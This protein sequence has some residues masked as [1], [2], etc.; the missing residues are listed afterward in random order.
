MGSRLFVLF[1]LITIYTVN[2]SA[3]KMSEK[4]LVDTAAFS[5]WEQVNTP[6]VSKNGEYA[7]FVVTNVK[8]KSSL[9]V[10][11]AID[12]DSEMEWSNSTGVSFTDDSRFALFIKNPDSLCVVELSTRIEKYIPNVTSFQIFGE[13]DAE[14]LLYR[15]KGSS[16]LHIL[17]NMKT[18][19]ECVFT[20]VREYQ[21]GPSGHCLLLISENNEGI[22][23]LNVMELPKGNIKLIWKGK[24]TSKPIFDNKGIQ[25]A[26]VAENKLVWTYKIGMDKALLLFD[27]QSNDLIPNLKFDGLSYFS[28]DGNQLFFRMKE[29]RALTLQPKLEGVNVDIWSYTD[30]KLQ[31]Q[32]LKELVQKKARAFMSVFDIKNHK[33]IRLEHE[34]EEMVPGQIIEDLVLVRNKGIGDNEYEWHWNNE[35]KETYF[36]ISIQSG[37]RNKISNNSIIKPSLSLSGK[38]VIYYDGDNR[39]YFSYETKTGLVRNLTHNI[40]TTWT[41]YKWSDAPVG[42]YR[43]LGIAGFSENDGVILIYDQYDIW[44]IDPSGSKAPYCLTNGYGRT[45]NIVF[46]LSPKYYIKPVQKNEELLLSA[47]DR[48]SKDNGFY[49]VKLGK[50]GDPH[51]LTMGPYMY[52][53]PPEE[54]I[55]GEFPQAFHTKKGAVWLLKR[56]SAEESPNWFYTTDFKSFKQLTFV[57]PEKAY[58]WLRTELVNFTTLDHK[59]SQGV[60]YKPENF[61]PNRKYPVIVHY[62][63]KKSDKLHIFQRPLP[64]YAEINIP[65]FVSNG[66]LVFTPDI[67]YEIGFPGES[68]L[69]SI[70]G[71]ANYLKQ[72]KWVDSTKMG[73]QGHSFGGYE[74]NYIISRT[75]FFAAAE[76]ASGWGNFISSYNSVR[77]LSDGTSRQSYYEMVRQRLGVTLWQ[78]ANYF[79]DNSPIF[80]ADKISTPLL[81]M[82]N[83]EDS[84]VFWEQGIEFFTA[85]RRLG[86]KVWMLQYDGEG[87]G[88]WWSQKNAID[89]TIRT[90]Q[91]F[92][93]YLKGEKSPKWMVGGIP[94]EK[95]GFDDGL[96]LIDAT[97]GLGLFNKIK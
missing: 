47:F 86:K 30:A 72:F 25:L 43:P 97:P 90:T 61:D 13:K 10:I 28:K 66:F 83:K 50:L 64:I 95:K 78:G 75:G 69:N 67:N 89:F 44:C 82:N 16:R 1:F 93:H 77:L 59:R 65:W 23:S 84:D 15:L 9:L 71:A 53:N 94:A 56:M 17:K 7:S 76:A 22:Q 18:G 70:M 24:L 58:N 60:L 88:L 49:T 54:Y 34:N 45:H 62:Y 74:T 85:L 91:F 21:I 63:E 68:A 46:R 57:Y 19:K 41:S 40:R 96:Q 79:I 29:N 31:S 11:K 52:T 35:A 8:T 32:Q 27:S 4:L 55:G 6:I 42:I 14:W 37:A 87:H 20:D 51:L 48:N 38:Y 92:N 2:A 39:N 36:L 12:R 5:D 80:N 3:Q 33:I 73:L 81:L 26:F